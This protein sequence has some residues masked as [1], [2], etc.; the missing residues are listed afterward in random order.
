[1]W[2]SLNV[3]GVVDDDSDSTSVPPPLLLDSLTLGE[4][5]DDEEEL[6]VGLS[7]CA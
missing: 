2:A 3:V 7:S 5:G 4:R 1:M 6:V